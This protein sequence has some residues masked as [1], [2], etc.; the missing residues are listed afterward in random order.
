MMEFYLAG[1]TLL[2]PT[3]IPRKRG[4][5]GYVGVR[6]TLPGST[7]GGAILASLRRYNKITAQ[8][9]EE[10]ARKY[11]IICSPAFPKQ[12]RLL[13]PSHPF[14]WRCKEPGCESYVTVIDKVLEV[15]NGVVELRPDLLKCENGHTALERRHPSPLP[16]STLSRGGKSTGDDEKRLDSVKVVSVAI[17]RHRASSIKGALYSYETIPTGVE[18]WAITAAE[19]GLLDEDRYLIRI[20][21]GISRGFG[22]AELSLKKIDV[23]KLKEKSKPESKTVV[24]Y[25]LSPVV[26]KDN[27]HTI[28]LRVYGDL[29]GTASGG[30]VS[31]KS[32]YGSPVTIGG[33]NVKSNLEWKVVNAASPGSLVVAELKGDDMDLAYGLT[34]LGL[35]GEKIIY[36][37]FQLV[38]VNMMF[39]AKDDLGDVLA[40]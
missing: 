33:W 40:S 3:I 26:L 31:V 10:I 19:K 6:E 23:E 15:L 36:D 32:V 27:N 25:S 38:G 5:R 2:S 37:N 35:I 9:A 28:D 21:R 29:T 30:V 11:S 18:Y 12:N 22:K 20:G 16:A 4:A 7:L 39:P 13:Y 34:F 14:I 1:L 8:K 24:L 17:S